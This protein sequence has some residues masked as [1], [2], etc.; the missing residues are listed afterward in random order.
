[1]STSICIID[2]VFVSSE[3]QVTWLSPTIITSSC[4]FNVYLFPF[5]VQ[6]CSLQF[7]PWARPH[8]LE[9]LDFFFENNETTFDRY[10]NNGVWEIFD[11][12][13]EKVLHKYAL[14]DEP[15]AEVYYHIAF[16]RQYKVYVLALI[17]PSL[18][19]SLSSLLIFLL[20]PESGE[21]ISFG[22]TNLL[23]MML[24]QETVRE[25]IPSTGY[26]VFGKNIRRTFSLMPK[27]ARKVCG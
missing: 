27:H 21:K 7:G 25:S 24:F 23:A 14:Y 26:P 4:L 11:E 6:N 20:P 18:M 22:I 10:R 12:H 15:Y 17:I 5:D 9:D 16:R 1:M 2:K 8:H 19:L 13:V 3:G